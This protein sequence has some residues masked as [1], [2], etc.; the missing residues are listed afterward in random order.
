[1][2]MSTFPDRSLPRLFDD[3]DELQSELDREL[4]ESPATPVDAVESLD[5]LDDLLQESVEIAAARKAKAQGRRLDT[6]MLDAIARAKV[7]ED[8]LAWDTI[9][10]IKI[11]ER[12]QCLCGWCE[13]HYH[14]IF[15]AMQHRKRPA[16]RQ[17]IQP[18]KS[19]VRMPLRQFVFGSNVPECAYCTPI[20]DGIQ[21]HEFPLLETFLPPESR[22]PKV[23]S[24]LALQAEVGARLLNELETKVNE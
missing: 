3:P 4:E 8:M 11:V 22:S 6:G 21:A 14:G 19:E 16:E 23:Q 15:K 20:V 24:A 1:M 9:A 10:F 7:I 13:T 12:R 5:D 2:S 18:D 17:L